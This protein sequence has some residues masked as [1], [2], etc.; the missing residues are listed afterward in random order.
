MA[1][2]VATVVA[3]ARE[4]QITIDAA[5]L[6]FYAANTFV[7][8]VV[9]TYATFT[10]VGTAN[11]LA[12]LLE[13]L[14]GLGAAEFQR[15]FEQVGDATAGRTRAV[16]LAVAI[17]AW[18]SF[19]LFGAVEQVF[20]AVYG[21]RRER[22]LLRRTVDSV[23]VLV[24]V[25][26]VVAGMAVGASLFLFRTSTQAWVLLGP[27]ALWFSLVV[28]F[29]PIYYVL[30]GDVSVREVLPGATFAA[31]G[32]AVSAVALRLYVTVSSSVHLYGVVGAVLLVLSW[33]Y[34]VGLSVLVGVVLNAHL[35]G[36]IDAEEGWYVRDEQG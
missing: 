18:S 34:V 2:R 24:T 27:V 22:G 3:I 32:W 36:R 20:A 14:T 21:T 6:A 5:G 16:A 11:A 23:L 1:S 15:L 12:G 30:S 13:A 7:A 35:A 28:L 9:L 10:A 26:L 31:T 19:R 29:T 8:L 33:L 25:T 17:S 4:K